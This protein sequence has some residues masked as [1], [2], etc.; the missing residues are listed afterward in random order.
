MAQRVSQGTGISPGCG[1]CFGKLTQC[2]YDYCAQVRTWNSSQPLSKARHL[3]SLM[4]HLISFM[5]I[6]YQFLSGAP[7][8]FVDKLFE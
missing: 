6:L 1:F 3:S 5:F 2:V 4:L 7:L 8:C